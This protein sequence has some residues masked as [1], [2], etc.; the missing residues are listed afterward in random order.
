VDSIDVRLLM[1]LGWGGATVTTWA[2]VLYRRVH[3]WR[4][5][6]DARSQ[7]EL[8]IALSLFL[9]S[10]ATLLSFTMVFFGSH[11]TDLRNL[12][13]ALALGAF[14]GAGIVSATEPEEPDPAED[15]S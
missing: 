2:Y 9:T 3:A 8:L 4:L 13:V 10:L 14:T 5:H 15:G 1:Y 7:R 6:H 12:L 11:G